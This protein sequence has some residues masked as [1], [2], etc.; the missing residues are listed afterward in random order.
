[1]PRTLGAKGKPKYITVTVAQINKIFAPH[2]KIDISFK[3]AYQFME[4]LDKFRDEKDKETALG[5]LIAAQEKL[6][7]EKEEKKR[8]KIPIKV[9][10]FSKEKRETVEQ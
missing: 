4:N 1:M 8:E 5:L 10:D 7:V 9:I 6:N 3:Y 2:A